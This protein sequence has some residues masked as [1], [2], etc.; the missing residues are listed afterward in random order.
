MF[1]HRRNTQFGDPRVADET[2][3]PF[4]E[5]PFVGERGDQ[6][7]SGRRHRV[8]GVDVTTPALGLILNIV[9]IRADIHG[10]QIIR[11]SGFTGHGGGVTLITFDTERGVGLMIEYDRACPLRAFVRCRLLVGSCE[12]P[13]GVEHIQ[14]DRNGR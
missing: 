1:R 13:V 5:M 10:G 2:V 3:V 4:L 9:A 14:I 6:C 7:Y 11:S 12:R 8:G